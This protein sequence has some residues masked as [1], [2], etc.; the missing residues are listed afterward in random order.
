MP[1]TEK[2]IEKLIIWYCKTKNISIYGE[3]IK[4]EHMEEIIQ[5]IMK[6]AK[7]KMDVSKVGKILDIVGFP[8]KERK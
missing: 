4:T 2:E 3:W 8:I 7:V 1:Y 6:F 5:F